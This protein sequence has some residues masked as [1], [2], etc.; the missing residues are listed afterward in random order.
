[1]QEA[2]RH[3]Q[4]QAYSHAQHLHTYAHPPLCTPAPLRTHLP[5]STPAYLWT[6]MPWVQPHTCA[7]CH[8]FVLTLACQCTPTNSHAHPQ[9]HTSAFT[10]PH[11]CMGSPSHAHISLCTLAHTDPF[12]APSTTSCNS[13]YPLAPEDHHASRRGGLP[14]ALRVGA[15]GVRVLGKCSSPAGCPHGTCSDPQ[16]WALTLSPK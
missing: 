9:P 2:P 5:T 3:S 13:L 4:D 8:M 12:H 15:A 1:M 10:H 14:L 11:T 16:S 7:H 6:L